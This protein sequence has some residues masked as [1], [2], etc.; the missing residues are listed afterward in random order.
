M[1]YDFDDEMSEALI[2]QQ[3]FYE[4]TGIDLH[5]INFMPVRMGIK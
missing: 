4:E 2:E 1:D 5:V 3:S